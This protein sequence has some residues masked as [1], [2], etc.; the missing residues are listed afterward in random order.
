MSRYPA[1]SEFEPLATLDSV[2]VE[3]NFEAVSLGLHWLRQLLADYV[4]RL[5]AERPVVELPAGGMRALT[6]LEADWLLRG[7]L[8]GQPASTKAMAA[9]QDYIDCR[10][11]MLAEGHPAA[12]DYLSQKFSLSE[13]EED[14]VLMA[15]APF[16]DATIPALY[17]YAH[18]RLNLDCPTPY[19]IV[20]LLAGDDPA[21]AMLARRFLSPA[22]PLRR[23]NLVQCPAE[24]LM[25][26]TPLVTDEALARF[27]AGEDGH[28]VRLRHMLRPVEAGP[29]I[30]EILSSAD[31]FGASFQPGQAGSALIY[32]P[33]RSGRRTISARLAS[34]LGLDL[35]E[36]QL[37][38][39]PPV[40][41]EQLKALRLVARESV[42]RRLAV[43]IDM[44]QVPIE[45]APSGGLSA[46]AIVE[47]L[48]AEDALLVIIVATQRPDLPSRIPSLR[49]VALTEAQRAALWQSAYPEIERLPDISAD[50]LAQHF[51]LGPSEIASVCTETTGA[52]D[53]GNLWRACRDA[54]SR[55]LDAMADRIEPRFGWDDIVIPDDIRADLKAVAA[56]V[57]HRGAVYG[58]GGFARKL[59]RGRGVSALFAGPSGVGK[60]MAA[61]VIARELDLD[62]YRI[63]LSRV[64]SKYIGETEQNLRRVFDA[65]E[66]GGAVLFFDEADALFGKRSEVKDSHDR[67]ANIEISYL[68]QRMETYSGLAVLATN[69]K[70][71]ID[72]AFLRRLRFVI[73][74]PFPDAALRETIWASAFPKETKT[75]GLDFKALGRLDIAGGSI[76]VIAVNAAF[77]AAAEGTPVRMDH[78][79]HAAR[80][81]M[82]KLDKEF[83]PS[84]PY[85]GV[86]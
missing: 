3:R 39:L 20:A 21:T 69:L 19:L 84:W 81:E 4:A 37:P 45:P 41:P 10:D 67:Y 11:A 77:R 23:H 6:D 7:G 2:W 9:R 60:T 64:I 16:L 59:V 48:L 54:A 58:D 26:L 29:C 49:T 35:R 62:L 68:L 83:R 66:A 78:I 15:L 76:V 55:G 25:A 42:L 56:Q 28:D 72:G 47:D 33:P 57:R 86:G 71:H 46:T 8:P 75:E 50:V 44:S 36:L 24:Q 74:L 5:R 43:L 1:R 63:D 17:G 32:G 34:G 73:D 80:A 30:A 40:G 22:A 53:G 51:Q 82:R 85:G 52:L 38:R 12:I 13:F 61:E 27:L 79:G 65:A 70:S 14:V 31:R 18:D